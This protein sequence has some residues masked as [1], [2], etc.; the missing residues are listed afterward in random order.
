[1]KIFKEVDNLLDDLYKYTRFAVTL[2]H[3]NTREHTEIYRRL[4]PFDK[5]LTY[6][7]MKQNRWMIL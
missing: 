7:W 5:R 2:R 6:I 1:M 4:N 3:L